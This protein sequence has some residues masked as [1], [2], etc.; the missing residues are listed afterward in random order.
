MF[1]EPDHHPDLRTPMNDGGGPE[2]GPITE[3][4]A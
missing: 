1:R 2:V 3:V 4:T